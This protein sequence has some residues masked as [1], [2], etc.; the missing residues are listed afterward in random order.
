[1][2]TLGMVHCWFCRRRLRKYERHE[3][4]RIKNLGAKLRRLEDDLDDAEYHLHTWG[5]G[6]MPSEKRRER[7]K[8]EQLSAKLEEAKTECS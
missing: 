4:K 8:I 3:A 6:M 7:E 1:V 5:F 2:Y